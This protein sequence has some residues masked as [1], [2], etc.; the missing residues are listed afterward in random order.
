MNDSVNNI[1]AKRIL[2]LDGAMGTMIQ[3]Y[4]LTEEDY[5]GLRFGNHPLAVKGNNDLLVLTQPGIIQEI[6]EKYLEAG[7]D[8]IETNTFNAQ[9]ISLADYGMEH[10][11]YEINVQAAKIARRAAEK[12][13]TPEKPRFV[14]GSIGP[15]NKTASISPDVNNPGFRAVTFDDISSAY[16]EQVRGLMDGGCDLLLVETIFDTLN[17]KACLYAIREVFAEKGRELPVMIS[18]TIT[19]ASGRTLSGQTPEAFLTS[20]SHFPFLSIGL[21]CA[22]GARQIKPFLEELSQKSSA[23]ISVYP[24]AGLPNQFGGYDETP[25]QM[26]EIIKEFADLRI[27]NIVGGCCGTG[28][29]HIRLMAEKVKEAVPRIPAVH[30]PVT[31]LSGLESLSIKK[32][33]NFINIGERT[34]VAGSKKFAR[35][36]REKKYEEAL[37][38]ARQQI[39]SGAQIIDVNLDDGM[40]DAEKEMET[41]L[42]LVSSDPDVARVPVMI[43]SSKFEVIEKGLQNLQ[44][45]P[46]VNSISLKEGE[47]VFLQRAE[48]IRNYGAAVVVMAFDETGQATDFAT[49]TQVCKRAYML[50][51]EKLNFPPEDIVFDCNILTVGTGMKEHNHFAFDFI[52]AVKWI[53]ENL[54]H[55]KTSGGVS[56][57]SFAFRGNDKVREAM[58]AVFLYHAVNAGLDMGIVNAGAL[59]VYDDIDPMLRI[60]CED[61]VLNRRIDATERLLAY[62]D[63]I[64][65][66]AEEQVKTETWRSQPVAERL[67]HSLVKGIADHVNED[68]AEALAEYSDALSIIE[69]PLMEGMN[70]VGELFGAGKMFLPQ[71][72]KS[73]RVMKKAVS[74]LQPVIERQRPEGA[75]KAAKIVL[76]TV[77]GDV[78]DIGKNIAGVILA[79]NN[80]EVIDLGIMVQ[81]EAIIAAAKE[82]QAD[83]IGLSG[84]ITPSLDEMIAVAAEM[85]KAGLKIPLIIGGATTSK[86]HNAVKI[87]PVYSGPVVHVRD[88]SRSVGIVATL[89]DA[90]KRAEYEKILFAE[91]EQIRKDFAE[92][93]SKVEKISPEEARA[94]RFIWTKENAKLATPAKHGITVYNDVPLESLVP[95]IDWTFFF[96]QWRLNGKYPEIFNDPVKGPEA[97]KLYDDAQV[98]LRKIVDEKMLRANAVAGIFEAESSNEDVKVKTA[99]GATLHFLRNCDKKDAGKYNLSLADYIAPVSSGVKDHIGL[100][101]VTAGLGIEKWEEHYRKNNDDYSSTMLRILSD[102]LAEALAEYLHREVRTKVWAYSPN[103]NLATEQLLK[104]EYRGIRP[105]PGYPACPVHSEKTTIFTLLDATKSTGITLT[106]NFAMSPAASVCGYYFA[107]PGAT[108]FT[109]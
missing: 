38:V 36:I 20:V 43:D 62:A 10:L 57:L 44:G 1:L 54:P 92:G 90:N 47:E 66:S 99:D 89:L 93:K 83:I 26:A 61:L 15:T 8:I 81:K 75:A 28:P 67:S 80:Y 45:K 79:C 100:F 41:F 65:D 46:I 74:I 51:T 71:V 104:G 22:L 82:H 18:V 76:A 85:E 109:V 42:R 25:E 52:K 37:T 50:L 34:N 59:P 95:L 96:H 108:Y 107:H 14:A 102:R 12:F 101:A 19:D 91:Y 31:R 13:S 60:L 88:A 64:K 21:N 23:F 11:A 55:A 33:A 105:A 40:L 9:R 68:I 17:A 48:T 32:E 73:A 16:A 94:N 69:G 27:A 6:H 49:K 29:E 78:H 84:L 7:A 87:A 63:T 2:V 53:K 86:I 4:K 5:R 35:L 77:K 72:M 30:E 106:E 24:N 56:N 70:R 103:E 3:Q 58:H 97:K 98:M 39:E